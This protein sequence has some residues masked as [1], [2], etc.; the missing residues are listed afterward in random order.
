MAAFRS[1]LAAEL[2]AA[3]HAAGQPGADS[4]QAPSPVAGAVA[5]LAA[6][7]EAGQASPALS[8]QLLATQSLLEA[9]LTVDPCLMLSDISPDKPDKPALQEQA[10]R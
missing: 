7:L 1:T 9:A 8:A 3:S 4:A 6:R 5:S 10:C 2:T